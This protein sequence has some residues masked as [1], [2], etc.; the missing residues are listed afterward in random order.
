MSDLSLLPATWLEQGQQCYVPQLREQR[1]TRC[2]ADLPQAL[3]AGIN[4]ARRSYV[5]IVNWLKGEPWR[6]TTKP[7]REL[8]CD[9]LKCAV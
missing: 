7:S 1:R 8:D 2:P 3:A 6:P 4:Q 9:L 5:R